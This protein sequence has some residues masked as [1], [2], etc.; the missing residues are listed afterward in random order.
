MGITTGLFSDV[1]ANAPQAFNAPASVA[2]SADWSKTLPMAGAVDWANVRPFQVINPLTGY[3]YG[4]TQPTQATQTTQAE[5]PQLSEYQKWLAQQSKPDTNMTGEHGE[6]RAQP[7]D[8]GAVIG[9][10]S[11]SGKAWGELTSSQQNAY[12]AAV[13]PYGIGPMIA[14]VATKATP[15]GWLSQYLTPKLNALTGYV[16]PD[17]QNA[18]S[19]ADYGNLSS[20][21]GTVATPAGNIAANPMSIDPAQAAAARGDTGGIGGYS[22]GGESM[23]GGGIAGYGGGTY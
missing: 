9:D 11:A 20:T 3:S 13:D 14:T 21:P 19:P 7:T 23:A 6:G 12:S 17:A 16:S 8:Y 10:P 18:Y 15:A 1:L 22:I 5:Q 4:A 2:G